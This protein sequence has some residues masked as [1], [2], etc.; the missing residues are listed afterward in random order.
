MGLEGV[1]LVLAVEERFGIVVRDEEAQRLIRVGDLVSLIQHKLSQTPPLLTVH[2]CRSLAC[3]LALRSLV[4]EIRGDASL[5]VRPRQ[6]VRDVLDGRQR[7]RLWRLISE[8]FERTLPPLAIGRTPIRAAKVVALSGLVGVAWLVLDNWRVWPFAALAW[9]LAG[10][11]WLVA[12]PRLATLPGADCDTFRKLTQR[13]VATL[14]TPDQT[15]NEDD[16]LERLRPLIC[17]TLFVEPH[18][19]TSD[20]RFVDDLGLR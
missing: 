15:P 5:R 4:R 12:F 20:A 19:V 1:E 11:A 17:E 2:P 10:I 9:V 16:I 6:R 14:P 18:V 8:R 13:L 7:R 3:F